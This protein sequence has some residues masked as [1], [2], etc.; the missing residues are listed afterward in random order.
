M[1]GVLDRLA[2]STR[3]SLMDTPP[4]PP[5][6]KTANAFSWRRVFLGLALIAG[7]A[8]VYWGLSS[9]GTLDIL[10]DRDALETKILAL[11]FWGPFAVI[12]LIAAAIV[13]SPIPSAPIALA[14]GAAY[15]H[16][17]GTIYIIIGA[18]AGALAA[19]AIARLV[20]RGVLSRWF[21][22][23]LNVGLLGSQN[24]LMGVVFVSRLLPFISFDIVSYAA[25]LTALKPW[26]FA[27]ATLAGIIPVSFLLAHF[28]GEMASGE[29]RRIMFAVLAL[30]AL[31]LLPF[32]VRYLQRRRD[33]A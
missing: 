32:A 12:T 10:L 13:L 20:G 31:T 21:G 29:S 16:T 18:E 22:D 8:A 23:R 11:G 28:G 2:G 1:S 19:F 30:G 4:P 9:T 15:G 5:T 25:G 14:A 24:A 7:L 33:K 27:A 6:N 3:L 26:R 17:L